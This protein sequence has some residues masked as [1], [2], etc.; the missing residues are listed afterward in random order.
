MARGTVW[1]VMTAL[2]ILGYTA[3]TNITL[4][5]WPWLNVTLPAEQRLELLFAQLNT[6]QI[7]AFVQGD[8]V[9]RSCSP[10]RRFQNY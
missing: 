8:T 4:T 1:R 10:C 7:Y 5:D 6:S 9:V 3:A 2:S